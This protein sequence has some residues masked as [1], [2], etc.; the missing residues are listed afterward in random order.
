MVYSKPHKVGNRI[1]AKWCWD[2]LYITLK[3]RGYEVSNFWASTVSF[4]ETSR[5]GFGVLLGKVTATLDVETP[6]PPTTN[7]ELFGV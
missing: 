5:A 6:K 2:S 3:D 4:Q 1:K 7:S